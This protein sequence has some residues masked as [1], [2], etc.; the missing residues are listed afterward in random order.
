MVKRYKPRPFN[1][2]VVEFGVMVPVYAEGVNKKIGESVEYIGKYY[3]DVSNIR[4]ND[5]EYAASIGR[6]ISKKIRIP[7]HVEVTQEHKA[8]INGHIYDIIAID[9]DGEQQ[10]ITLEAVEGIK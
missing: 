8:R 7:A 10:Y 2:G 4:Q 5:F 1:S 6:M 3:F 9:Y